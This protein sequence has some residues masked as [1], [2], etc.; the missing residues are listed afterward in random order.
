[1][2][3]GPLPEAVGVDLV[4]SQRPSTRL[5]RH[6]AHES[7]GISA[8]T[9]AFLF[10][11]RCTIC[12]FLIA[13]LPSPLAASP[14]PNGS[15]SVDALPMDGPFASLEDYCKQD[16]GDVKQ[17]MATPKACGAAKGVGRLAGAF[18]GGRRG[19]HRC[20]AGQLIAIDAPPTVG[21][22]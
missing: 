1:M 8:G 19:R 13:L 20:P 7:T 9:R 10:V 12:T 15:D 6:R 5:A 14:L 17:C 11:T 4:V 18:L 21:V 3:L 22:T 2:I 16:G